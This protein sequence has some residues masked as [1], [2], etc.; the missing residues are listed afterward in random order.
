[1]AVFTS[2]GAGC[3]VLDLEVGRRRN[4]V[5]LL[6]RRSVARSA[7]CAFISGFGFGRDLDRDAEV[8]PVHL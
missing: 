2:H 5:M 6:Y 4:R 7:V 3:R 1:M 8:R